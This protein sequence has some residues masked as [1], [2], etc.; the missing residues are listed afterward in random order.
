MQSSGLPGV[1]L[2]I[3]E[4]RKSSQSFVIAY[5]SHVKMVS[6]LLACFA[7]FFAPEFF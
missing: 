5:L 1:K 4:E 2:W 6:W 3:E 7:G